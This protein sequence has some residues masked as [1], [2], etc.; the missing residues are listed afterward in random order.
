MSKP[1]INSLIDA[2]KVEEERSMAMESM[3]ASA[4][5]LSPEDQ[6]EADK[7]VEQVQAEVALELMDKM[8]DGRVENKTNI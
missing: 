8:P 3:L 2:L 7:L 5:E 6:L 4:T 1:D